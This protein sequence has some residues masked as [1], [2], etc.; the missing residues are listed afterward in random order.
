MVPVSPSVVTD[1]L[2]GL[3]PLSVEVT[4]SVVSVVSVTCPLVETPDEL[5]VGTDVVNTDAVSKIPP[6]VDNSLGPAG[7]TDGTRPCPTAVDTG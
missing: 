4:V 1:V 6:V 5:E 3:V 2:V 7:E